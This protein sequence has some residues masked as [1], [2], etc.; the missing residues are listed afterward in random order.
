M[1]TASTRDV[2]RTLARLTDPL[3]WL[4]MGALMAAAF[5]S[6]SLTALW[7]VLLSE[8]CQKIGLMAE[9]ALHSIVLF[10]LVFVGG[11]ALSRARAMLVETMVARLECRVRMLS[12][13]KML[14]LPVGYYEGTLSGGLTAR[15]NYS[16]SGFSQL[17]KIVSNDVLPALFTAGMILWRTL[18]AAPV[19]MTAIM[20]GYL[21]VS[22]IVSAFQIRSQNGIRERIIRMRSDLDGALCQSIVNIELIRSMDADLYEQQRLAPAVEGVRKAETAHHLVMGSFDLA[23]KVVQAVT[24]CLLL[25][26]CYVM[27]RAG[28]LE[29]AMT[30][31]VLLLFQQLVAPTESVYRCMDELVSS[32]V[33]ARTLAEIFLSEED[34]HYAGTTQPERTGD[35]LAVRDCAIQAP[36]GQHTISAPPDFTVHEKEVVAL[37]GPAGCGK[38][39]VLR[40]MKGYFPYTGSLKLCGSEVDTYAVSTLADTIFYV[41]QTALFFQGTVREN[42]LYGTRSTPT[43]EQ[44]LSALSRAQLL[45]QLE[46]L[47]AFPLDYMVLEGGKNLSAGQRQRLALARVFLHRFRLLILDESTANIDLST[48]KRALDEVEAYARDQRAAI[49]YISH[50][51]EVVARCQRSVHLTPMGAGG[52]MAA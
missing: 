33:K 18:T 48:M 42:L 7:P 22:V 12:T 30:L 11:E 31:T 14:R 25:A 24:F 47:C 49:I 3:T 36:L 1:K 8:A 45:D 40:G 41:P 6:A 26:C 39:S 13:R 34:A 10:A 52:L 32:G 38:T 46:Q 9:D 51:P 28:H 50:E 15:M 2:I 4:G 43:D 17:M 23:K 16:I 35:I 37:C 27:T 21:V 20:V 5:A 19:E 29:G 44:L